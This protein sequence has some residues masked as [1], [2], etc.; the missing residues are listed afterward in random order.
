MQKLFFIS[1]VTF[2]IHSSEDILASN[3]WCGTSR[4]WPCVRAINPW[5]KIQLD[6]IDDIKELLKTLQAEDNINTQERNFLIDKTIESLDNKKIREYPNCLLHNLAA[7]IK[8]D[9]FEKNP[10][11]FSSKEQT[12]FTH[13][14]LDIVEKTEWKYIQYIQYIQFKQEF[15]PEKTIK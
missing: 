6:Y 1:L 12:I 2:S 7:R 15:Y 3:R 9:L 13:K 8:N 11:I 10:L 5:E 4:P 14:L